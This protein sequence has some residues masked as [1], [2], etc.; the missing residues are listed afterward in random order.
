MLRRYG[1]PLSQTVQF[2]ARHWL[3]RALDDEKLSHKFQD[4]AGDAGSSRKKRKIIVVDDSEVVLTTTSETLKRAGYRVL[5][6]NG[7]SG[8]VAMILQEKPDLVLLDVGMPAVSGDTIVK[9]L[10][11][12]APNSDTILLLFSEM[13]EDQLRAKAKACGAHGYITKTYNPA[14]LLRT[15]NRWLRRPPGQGYTGLFPSDAGASG[16]LRALDPA[17]ASGQMRIPGQVRLSGELKAPAPL[18][19]S[20]EMTAPEPPRASGEMRTPGHLGDSGERAPGSVK[21]SGEM[22]VSSGFGRTRS[23][24]GDE[25]PRVLFLDD[26]MLVLSGYRRQLHGQPIRFEFALSGAEAMRR[27]T[28]HDPPSLIVADLVMPEPDGAQVFRRALDHDGSWNRR[29]VIVTGM[30]MAEAKRQLDSRFCGYL[31]Q[32]PVLSEELGA[33]IR[34]TLGLPALFRVPKIAR[35]L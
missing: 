34:D 3:A 35:S 33:A 24:S 6:R 17:R 30:P 20:G 13:E 23:A 15:I 18:R 32:K 29:F 10:G 27:L 2:R 26:D 9:L 28:S 7:P 5:T 4:D 22:R 19:L 1:S 25:D 12:A 14:V 21:I 31:F 16:Q 8:C 11:T